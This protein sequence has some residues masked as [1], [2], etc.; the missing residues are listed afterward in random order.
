MR[1]TSRLVTAALTLLSLLAVGL[2]PAEAAVPR[3]TGSFTFRQIDL[4][5]TVSMKDVVVGPAPKVARMWFTFDHPREKLSIDG[6]GKSSAYIV[7][8]GG[9]VSQSAYLVKTSEHRAYA[10]FVLSAGFTPGTYRATVSLKSTVDGR[11]YATTREDVVAF[12]VRRATRMTVSSKRSGDRT[13]VSGRLT[14]WRDVEYRTAIARRP[15]AGVK[16]RL[17]F[18]PAGATGPRYVTTVRTD[19][20][21][22]FRRTLDHRGKGRWVATFAGNS[23]HAATGVHPTGSAEPKVRHV[24][25]RSRTSHGTKV[26]MKVRTRD[27][28]VAGRTETVRVEVEWSADGPGRLTH[29][30]T[31]VCASSRLGHYDWHCSTPRGSGNKL[32]ADLYVGPDDPAGIYDVDVWADPAL[33]TGTIYFPADRAGSFRVSKATRTKVHVS[34]SSV[35]KGDRVS[36]SGTLRKPSQLDRWNLG[37]WRAAAGEKV[38]IYFDPAGPGGPVLKGIDTVDADGRFRRWFTVRESGTWVVRYAGS[39]AHHLRAS[40]AKVGVTVS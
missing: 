20:A 24:L 39:S 12:Q 18:D 19:D 22:R 37:G 27:A 28:V 3:G 31:Y 21:G 8:P 23:N 15:L 1:R 5:V 9:A 30:T 2:V 35:S 34:D 40:S 17:S 6:L 33:D 4:D 32:V 10:D 7:G 13:V 11:T 14:R 38:K 25:T 16:V 26:T 29:D 36:V